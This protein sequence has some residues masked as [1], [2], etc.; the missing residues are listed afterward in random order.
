MRVFQPI[1]YTRPFRHNVMD[2]CYFALPEALKGR[3][4]LF[5]VNR[6]VRN[7]LAVEC[8]RGEIRGNRWHVFRFDDYVLVGLATQSFGR[9]DETGVSIRGYYGLLMSAADARLPA[10]SLFSFLDAMFVEPH[11]NDYRNFDVAYSPNL[12]LPAEEEPADDRQTVDSIAFNLDEGKVLLLPD[13]HSEGDYLKQAFDAARRHRRFEFVYGFNTEEHACELPV[14]NAVC[15][16]GREKTVT[17]ENQRPSAPDERSRA[18]ERTQTP[19]PRTS[20]TRSFGIEYDEKDAGVVS[21]II[22]CLVQTLVWLDAHL[23][24]RERGK[25]KFR[26][27]DSCGDGGRA[28]RP[29]GGSSSRGGS[30]KGTPDYTFGMSIE[31]S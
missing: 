3:E 25:E 6:H 22:Q 27:Y 5:L 28:G 10:A 14:M 29:G 7:A 2:Y 16:G 18:E 20:Q 8:G 4:S 11:F 19:K 23:S 1:V 12:D 26:I 30:A 15:H 17:L 21:E 31:D 24:P 9:R 13:T